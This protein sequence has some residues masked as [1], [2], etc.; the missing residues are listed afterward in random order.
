MSIDYQGI[1][2]KLIKVVAEGFKTAGDA[3]KNV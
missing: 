2:K 3:M 1:G